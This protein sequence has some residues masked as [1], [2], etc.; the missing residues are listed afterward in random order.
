MFTASIHLLALL[1]IIA[2]NSCYLIQNDYWKPSPDSLIHQ[3]LHWP[4]VILQSCQLWHL[5]VSDGV[6]LFIAS[7]KHCKTASAGGRKL[8]FPCQHD[9]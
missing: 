4:T 8:P 2:I 9:D 5:P 1:F 7:S 3:R 6:K